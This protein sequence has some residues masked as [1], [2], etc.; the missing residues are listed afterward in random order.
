MVASGPLK[1]KEPSMGD[2]S[3]AVKTI[4]RELIRAIAPDAT[5]MR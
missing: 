3:L 4:A 2:A 1:T 5:T